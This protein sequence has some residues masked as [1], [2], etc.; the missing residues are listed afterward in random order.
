[1]AEEGVVSQQFGFLTLDLVL[2]VILPGALALFLPNLITPRS[3]ET[4]NSTPISGLFAF[5]IIGFLSYS[6]YRA[7][8]AGFLSRFWSRQLILA[9]TMIAEV[10]GARPRWTV[11]RATYIGW[12][13]VQG[14]DDPRFRYVRRLSPYVHAGYQS[15]IIFLIFAVVANQVSRWPGTDGLLALLGGL[16]LIASA[17]QDWELNALERDLLAASRDSFRTYVVQIVRPRESRPQP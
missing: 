8:Y 3:I 15:A 9:R 17:W 4:L 7:F 12:R 16:L 2:R 5:L 10:T 6:F 14:S 13:E 1:M 11:V